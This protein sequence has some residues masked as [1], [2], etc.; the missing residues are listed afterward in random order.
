[1]TRDEA[2]SSQLAP[3][4][5]ELKVLI[6]LENDSGYETLASLKARLGPENN[7]F[8]IKTMNEAGLSHDL[9]SKTTGEL[10]MVLFDAGNGTTFFAG[11]KLPPLENG[12]RIPTTISVDRILVRN[13]SGNFSELSQRLAENTELSLPLEAIKQLGLQ[14]KRAVDRASA[15][16]APLQ[17]DQRSRDSSYGRA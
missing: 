16:A 11:E 10:P 5:R 2:G 1:M 15:S 13:E 3:S 8:F 9:A 4:H 12:R 7:D 17:L 14:P 6:R